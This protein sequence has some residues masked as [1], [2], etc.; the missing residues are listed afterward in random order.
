VTN[1]AGEGGGGPEEV[2]GR[3]W[4]LA[5]EHVTSFSYAEPVRSSFNEVRMAPLTTAR[6]NTLRADVFTAPLTAA[7][8][9]TDYWGTRMLAFDIAQPHVALEIRAAATVDTGPAPEVPVNASWDEIEGVADRFAEYLA[10]TAYTRCDD[11]LDDIGGELRRDT[12]LGTVEAVLS[13][14]YEAIAYEPGVTSVHTSAPEVVAAGKGVCQDRAHVA[15]ALLRWSGIPARYVSGY[16]HPHLDPVIGD[17]VDG[18]SHAWMEVW[19]GGWWES[20]PTNPGTVG[21]RH[22]TVGRGRDYGDV[23]PLKGIYAGG[24]ENEMT[25][26][27]RITRQM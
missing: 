8:W 22:V 27:V 26:V 1:I 21:R 3:P 16:L 5:I 18:Q 13:W 12:P 19:T 9:Y 4:R 17:T 15:L 10:P 25:T 14:V 20:D 24:S 23:A 11:N 6:Q 7:Y 2:E